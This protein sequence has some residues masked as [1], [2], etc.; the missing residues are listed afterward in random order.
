M[1]K[2]LIKRRN[3]YEEGTAIAAE[4]SAVKRRCKIKNLEFLGTLK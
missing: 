3:A 2:N 1:T 4:K